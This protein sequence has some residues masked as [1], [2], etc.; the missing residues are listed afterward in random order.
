[1][2]WLYDLLDCIGNKGQSA[3]LLLIRLYIGYQAVIS[4]YAHLTHF[5][6]TVNAFI[7]WHVPMPQVNVLISALTELVGG[8]CLFLG[9]FTRIVAIPMTFN[10]IVAI[11]VS[12]L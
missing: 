1:M 2:K 6:Q 3:I 5:Q 4:G 12:N 9:L 11:L 8:I 10:F 7:S